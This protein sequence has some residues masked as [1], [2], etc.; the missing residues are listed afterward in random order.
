MAMSVVFY[1]DVVCPFAY[2][3]SRL[4]EAL[5]RRTGAVVEWRPVLLGDCGNTVLDRGYL[6]VPLAPLP[7][8]ALRGYWGAPGQS[9]I[10]HAGHECIKDA[11]CCSR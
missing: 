9:W 2:M 6:I 7:R 11:L 4:V 5:G 1:Y 3:A 8:W 10:R